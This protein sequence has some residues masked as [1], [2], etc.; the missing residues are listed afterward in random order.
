MLRKLKKEL[1]I[2][3]SN[4][5]LCRRFLLFKPVDRERLTSTT[6]QV[7]VI[8]VVYG[9][10]LFVSTF[11][12]SLPHPQFNI[13]GLTSLV[14]IVGFVLLTIYAVT[15]LIGDESIR[16]EL[17]NVSMG[18]SVWF[19]LLW[20]VLWREANFS[21]YWFYDKHWFVYA[22]YNIAYLAVLIGAL[23][24]L[25]EFKPSV[26]LKGT[27]AFVLLL[28][29]P[30]HYVQLGGF[31]Y[32]AY[33]LEA[34]EK[35][36]KI[37]VEEV[38]YKQFN[39][40]TDIDRQVLPER[41][42][43]VDLYFVGFGSYASEDVFMKEV[44][45]ARNLFDERFDTKGRSVAMINNPKTV[46]TTP[47]ASRSNLQQILEKIGRKMNID[48]DVLFLYL[49]SHGSKT[50]Q[51]SVEFR[52]LILNTLSP[53]DLK[54]SLDNSGIKWRVLLVSACYSGGFVE[55]LK[56]DNTLVMTASD[57]DHQSFGCGSKSDF[58][59]FGKAVFDEQLSHNFN[60]I[61][62]FNKALASIQAREQREK[63]DSSHPQ[64]YVGDRIREKLETLSLDL[65]EYDRKKRN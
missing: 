43:I 19:Y 14:A 33:P 65:T 49:T 57:P 3:A 24:R 48:E 39:Y 30:L 37:N 20:L 13:Y 16:L 61:S 34:E 12:L 62:A 46:D 22:L 64:L 41:R 1:A 23:V 32:E 7:V 28:F 35:K 10:L 25:N 2:C 58:T 59:Y 55:T 9:L 51:L 26:V 44:D 38:Y 4:I 52:P 60:F 8:S 54:A 50:H 5:Y 6:D 31:W 18:I 63:R 56:N 36:S 11:F 42:G 29:V 40:L 53:G 27:A 45:Y 47:I 15:K 17:L 21:I